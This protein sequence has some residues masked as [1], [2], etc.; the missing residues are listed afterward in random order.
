[1]SKLKNILFSFQ[2]TAIILFIFAVSIGTATF[3]ENDFGI[4]TSW[5]V[6][7]D[8][9][10]FEIMLA[11]GCV[12]MI[13]VIFRYRLY[14]R[15]KLT[16]FVFHIAFIVILIGAGITRYFGFTGVMP[17]REGKSSNVVLSDQTYVKIKLID[18]PDSLQKY[19][20]VNFN[21][22]LKPKFSKDLSI[23][24]KEVTVT[25][26]NFA[27][28]AA[29]KPEPVENGKPVIQMIRAGNQGRVSFIMEHGDTRR[30]NNKMISFG[31]ENENAS[32][33]IVHKN[34]AVWIK[35]ENPITRM[36]MM[37]QQTDTLPPDSLHHFV[38]R[39]LYSVGSEK[40]V[41]QNFISSGT[42]IPKTI[43]DDDNQQLPDGVQFE[44]SHANKS[45][46][47]T[48]W[49]AK[50]TM[51]PAA[52][53]NFED[54][55]ASFAYG[56]KEVTLPFRIK[57]NDFI[58]KRYPG[59]N[60]PSW[61]ESKVELI[62]K[63]EGYHEK[64]RIYMN[65]ILKYK[66]YR[67][68]QSSYDTDELGTVLSVN[69]DWLGTIISYLGYTMLTVG[70]I[71]SIFNKNSRFT[72]LAKKVQRL[73]NA[74]M[75]I[76]LV[77][78]LA[79]TSV[80]KTQER[81]SAMVV[82]AE[83]ARKFGEL[84][85]QDNGGRIKPVNSMSSEVLRKISR[86]ISVEGLNADQVLLGILIDPAYWQDQPIIKVSH[87]RLKEILNTDDKFVAFNDVF[88]SEKE[89][90][91]LLSD[92]VNQAYQKRAAMRSKFDTEVMKVDERINIFFLTM[93]ADLMKIFPIPK[94][95]NNKWVAPNKVDQIHSDDTVFVDN[96]FTYY[97]QTVEQGVRTGDYAD[98]DTL[99]YAMKLYQNKYAGD[100]LP[101]QQK[102]DMEIWYNKANP[103]QTISKYYGV[104]GFILLI[105]LFIH[106]FN[107]KVRLYNLVKILKAAVF[108]IFI[109]HTLG[110]ALRWYISG[111]APWSN[112]YESMIYISWATV[113]AGFVFS[114]KSPITV[115]AT[116]LLAFITLHVAHLSW[117]DPEITNLVPVLK[118]YWLVI[119]VAIIT[120]SYG[121][122]ALGALMAFLNLIIMFFQ[123]QKQYQQ[124]NYTINELSSIIE[125]T[126]TIGL[127]MLTI[128]TFLGGVWANES[129]GRYWAWDPKE[130]WA[131]VSI[132]VYAFILH[133]RF[134][135]GLQGRFLFNFM[136]LI[137][138]SSII[139]TYFGVNYYLSG[140]HSYAKGDPL[141]VPDF[142]YY[143]LIIIIT[144][145]T[146]AYV[147]QYNLN[148][149]R[150][151]KDE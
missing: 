129:W 64:K 66:G 93:R 143:T 110:L 124:T 59:S 36:S 92:Y 148:K 49:G 105:L 53:I 80:A 42:V 13:G 67:F 130:T 44:I 123:N 68:Y 83:H 33:Q 89:G 135:P 50:N 136:S 27:A 70:F 65:N 73:K 39:A 97:L 140:L 10:W 150:I 2:L 106:V 78:L 128:G 38:P 114:K 99:L 54:V 8:A 47:V 85:V 35:S 7:Y 6:V 17:I 121:F 1:M 40:L 18:G 58:L 125:M 139:M 133:M 61:F 71:L 21:N 4:P 115:A 116:A 141:P 23:N 20:P 57:L 76:L 22:L 149:K 103:F 120:A 48:V 132:L 144:I 75:T 101:P 14:H 108:L 90:F 30:F 137:G 109:A 146:L 87:D 3:I 37:T 118:S 25:V 69:K 145:A 84:L 100:I 45:E 31:H 104:V 46:L 32:I 94:D 131:L 15:S 102:I 113:L 98:A 95:P 72:G 63:K 19:Y 88:K 142:V 26:R 52:D 82:D 51:A 138:F 24:D 147:N 151:N 134:V 55:K 119:H 122:L 29:K 96:I 86:K 91:Y 5:A 60:S 126:L 62:D 127:Y 107:P 112:G 79:I 56:A 43:E 81:D 117:M 77:G 41:M 28:N 9:L 111:H 34:E 16:I 12:N 11:L 74:K